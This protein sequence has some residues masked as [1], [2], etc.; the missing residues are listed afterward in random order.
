MDES[1]RL[2]TLADNRPQSP[3]TAVCLLGGVPP[4]AI[5]CETAHS[6]SQAET[7]ETQA[8]LV[9][10]LFLCAILIPLL[11]PFTEKP[12]ISLPCHS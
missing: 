7:Q 12:G 6:G 2:S 4:R 5:L 1:P 11:S 10:F 9:G 3:D 8:L